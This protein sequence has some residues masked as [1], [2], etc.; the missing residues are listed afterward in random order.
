MACAGSAPTLAEEGASVPLGIDLGGSGPVVSKTQPRH[1][2]RHAADEGQA[3]SPEQQP[4]ANGACRPQRRPRHRHRQFRRSGPAQDQSQPSADPRDR[5]AGDDDGVSGRPS[6]D[7][8]AIKPGTR[9]N[10]TIEQGQAG[11]TKSRRSRRRE[12]ADDGPRSL[13][14]PSYPHP[15]PFRAGRGRSRRVLACFPGLCTTR[16]AAPAARR[17]SAAPISRWISDRCR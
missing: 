4:N 16:L 11:C 15:P 10:F 3:F 7:L 13:C 1:R 9:V 6:I 2:R 5:L 12:V 8:K 14:S 17:S